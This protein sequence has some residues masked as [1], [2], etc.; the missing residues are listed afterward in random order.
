MAV[1]VDGISTRGV[2]P[3]AVEKSVNS[4]SQSRGGTS[5]VE[6]YGD[7]AR[8]CLEEPSVGDCPIPRLVISMWARRDPVGAKVQSSYHAL[9]RD[10]PVW[11]AATNACQDLRLHQ[12]AVSG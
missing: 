2:L 8:L 7:A 4:Y 6:T 1:G 5:V 10:R 9:T 3:A 11:D 12:L